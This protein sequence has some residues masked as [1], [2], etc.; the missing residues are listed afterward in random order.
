MKKINK[1]DYRI[2][3]EQE[4][5]SIS[6]DA[7]ELVN[8]FLDTHI[9]AHY[10][11]G[12]ENYYVYNKKKGI[13]EIVSKTKI[14][15]RII[16]VIPKKHLRAWTPRLRDKVYEQLNIKVEKW[17]TEIAFEEPSCIC[18]PNA[19]LDV[20]T[21]DCFAHTSKYF[22]TSRCEYE[23]DPK[24]TCPLFQEYLKTVCCGDEKLIQTMFEMLG[25][26]LTHDTAAQVLFF[27]YGDGGNGKSVLTALLTEL[28]G[29]Q[30]CTSLTPAELEKPFS[31]AK[32][33]DKKVL[34][35]PDMKREDVKHLMSAEV[36]K[37]VS[38]DVISA[39]VKYGKSFEFEP[40]AKIVISS[41]FPANFFY[42]ST[43]GGKRRYFVLPFLHRITDKERD[44]FL[45]SKLKK[46]LPGILNLAI[47]GYQRLVRR[48]YRFTYSGY[49]VDDKTVRK[50]SPLES[51]INERLTI[52]QGNFL[53]YSSLKSDFAK[54][55]R[56]NE[57][58]M[59]MPDSKE[60]RSK[61]ATHF[62][63]DV[64]VGKRNGNRG[65]FD[66]RIK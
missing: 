20:A 35:I 46:E 62:Q 49:K 33:K 28:V 32:I 38:G 37:L 18:L 5:G 24:A 7:S 27:L 2:V 26:C 43:H 59:E 56:E 51:Y 50:A 60:F 9:V 8:Y 19:V 11:N 44:P 16:T 40:K 64:K 61:I 17:W 21:G 31:R 36:K 52:G 15:Q 13:W 6:I 14:K 45:I 4:N 3:V 47:R 54:Y 57:L 30:N 53:L 22:F 29:N 65:I 12:G 1:A 23:F 34:L 25:Y 39:E 55:C 58:E 48:N 10:E 66:I 41:N 42:D 63:R